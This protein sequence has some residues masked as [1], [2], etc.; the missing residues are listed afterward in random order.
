MAKK[1]TIQK[2]VGRPRMYEDAAARVRAFRAKA[3]YPGHRYDIYLN[4]DAHVMVRVLMKQRGE[5][6][7]AVID[8]VLCGTLKL[9]VTK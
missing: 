4:K 7:S 3:A 6:A 9:P 5:S 8:A 1:T 2:T